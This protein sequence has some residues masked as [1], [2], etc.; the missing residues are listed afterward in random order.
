MNVPKAA[1]LF[2]LSAGVTLLGRSFFASAA[3][4]FRADLC[5]ETCVEKANTEKQGCSTAYDS[6]ASACPSG[7]TGRACLI[8]CR[9]TRTTFER[10]VGERQTACEKAC[11]GAGTKK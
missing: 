8:T 9:A 2:S 11:T 6:C 3:E 7:W 10:K 4:G 1:L 5:H